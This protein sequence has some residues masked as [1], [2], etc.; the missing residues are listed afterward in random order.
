MTQATK[1]SRTF[2]SAS[3]EATSALGEA[4]GSLLAPG[5][6]IGLIGD[7]G[8]GKTQ[9]VRGVADGAG[10][11]RADVSSPTFAIV[12]PYQGRI[13][14]HHADLYR[15]ADLDELYATGFFD[16]IATEGAMLVEWL[17]KIP[18]AAPVELLQIAI[19]IVDEERRRLHADAVGTRHVRLLEEWASV[20]TTR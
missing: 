15:L 19:E 6:F 12:Y 3:P 10:V 8:A 13:L 9:F 17:D 16:L 5:H 2:D 1:G 11:S 4:L 7:L 20:L 18:A 14:L